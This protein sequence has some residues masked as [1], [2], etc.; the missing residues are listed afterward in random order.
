MTP[1][2]PAA[3]LRVA[4]LTDGI[5]PHV[6][7]GMQRHSYYLARYLARRNVHVDLY[8]C[9]SRER[10][11]ALRLD[12]FAPEERERVRGFLV[13]FPEPGRLPGHYLRESLEFSRRL[14][15]VYREQEP[16]DL[17]YAKGF[18]AWAFLQARRRG[19]ALP[20]IGVK[21]HGYEMYQRGF[22]LRRRLEGLL[23]RGPA[24]WNTVHADRVFSYGGRITDIIESLGVPRG[25]IVEIPTGIEQ[26][27]VADAPTVRHDPLRFVFVG[28][29]ERRKGVPELNAALRALLPSE[30]FEVLFVGEV[31]PELRLESPR[32]THAGV[33]T[34][35]AR[36]RELTASCDVLLCPSLAEGM[37][38]VI[39]EGM[40]SG[41][42]V[43]ASDVGA[44][45]LMTSQDTGWLVPPGDVGALTAALREALELPPAELQRRKQAALRF[46]RENLLWED[47]IDRHVEAFRRIVAGRFETPGAGTSG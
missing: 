28:R 5:H 16:V 38:N 33:V 41:L 17:I 26:A 25:R 10:E 23:L 15:E 43:I 32:V 24:R 9:A 45:R 42:A 29:H 19:A 7:G 2:E 30:R 12:A 21:F 3:S 39:V 22:T 4:L 34:D 36:M 47:V 13:D 1:S 14:L 37:P 6:V 27:H 40:A 20:P 44:V 35:A 31:P 8:H 11:A 18:T 46:V